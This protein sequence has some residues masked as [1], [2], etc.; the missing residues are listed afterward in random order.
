MQLS[1]LCVLAQWRLS[2]GDTTGVSSAIQGLRRPGPSP[3]QL[4]PV[5]AAPAV[6]AGL[7][8]AWLVT[9]TKPG[10]AV[11]RLRRLDSLVLSPEIAAD[12]IAYAPILM[13]RLYESVGQPGLA[14]HAI[15]KRVYMS[16]W[17]RYLATAWREEGRLAELNGD[18]AGARDVYRRYLAIR[19]SPESEVSGQVK[20]V[21]RLLAALETEKAP[22]R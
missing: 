12:A 8:E 5:S 11:P 1:N 18:R 7:L 15:R 20:E 4:P 21:Q 6:C 10:E 3:G 22:S 14:L 9:L 2:K 13:A 16:G 17:P 19:H